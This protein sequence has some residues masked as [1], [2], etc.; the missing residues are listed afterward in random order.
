MEEYKYYLL[1]EDGRVRGEAGIDQGPG[2]VKL[3]VNP[4]DHYGVWDGKKWIED[5]AAREAD[6]KD[7]ALKEMVERE[8]QIMAYERVLNKI[9]SSG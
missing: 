1:Y 3:P 4:Y 2:W 6:E 9:K 8:I 7:A 5:T